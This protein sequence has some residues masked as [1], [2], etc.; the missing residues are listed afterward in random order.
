MKGDFTRDTFDQKKHFSRVLMQQ[1]RV[2]LDA[3]FNEQTA[4]LLHYMQ[5]LAKDIGGP[6]WGPANNLGF[7]LSDSVGTEKGNFVIGAGHYYVDGILI[8]NETPLPYLSQPGFANQAVPEKNKAYYV[9]LDIWERHVTHLQDETLHEA[10]LGKA[11]TCSRAQVVWQV[12]L[13]ETEDPEMDVSCDDVKNFVEGLPRL[14]NAALRARVHPK[15][16]N[17]NACSIPPESRYRGAGNQLYRIEI[18][19]GGEEAWNGTVEKDGTLSGNTDKAATFKWSR[20]N[21][22]MVFPIVSQNGNLVTLQSLGHD[23]YSMLKEDDWVEI[24][25][26]EV[27]LQGE[28]GILAQVEEIDPVEMTVK[29]KLPDNADANDPRFKWPSYPAKIDTHPLLRRWDHG[30]LADVPMSEGAILISESTEGWIKIEQG[31]EVQFQPGGKYRA[32]DFWL[33]P[34]RVATGGIEWHLEIG[35]DGSIAKDEEDREIHQSLP[36][37]G[38]EHHYAPLGVVKDQTITKRCQCRLNISLDCADPVTASKGVK[39]VTTKKLTD[40]TVR[41]KRG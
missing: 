29:L 24:V 9:F 16:Q 2:Q 26:D 25:D 23:S 8:E 30:T 39:T 28:A 27:E 37:H 3:D 17:D 13:E 35:P 36:P 41:S 12:R 31:I 40:E 21:G 14:D 19:R 20:D 4:I 7:A 11:D 22:S 33:I 5:T 18:Q 1:G 34:A 15:G 38:I 6:Y 10:A 32:G